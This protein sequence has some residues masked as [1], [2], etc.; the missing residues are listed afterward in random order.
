MALS[1]PNSKHMSCIKFTNEW[2]QTT[3]LWYQ[4]RP[5]CQLSHNNCPNCYGGY[6]ITLFREC[7]RRVWRK[8]T[9]VKLKSGQWLWLSWQR[10]YFQHQMSIVRIQAWEFL[11]TYIYNICLLFVNCWKDENEEKEAKW[12]THLENI[13][14]VL[15]YSSRSSFFMFLSGSLS[16]SLL[17]PHHIFISTMK[18]TFKRK[19]SNW[20]EMKKSLFISFIL[21]PTLW[22]R[23]VQK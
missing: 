20:R 4:K 23:E 17:F 10:G 13:S 19:G 18:V 7:H 15:L 9:H 8:I 21:R 2:I 22:L 12:K 1:R 11:Y 6:Q 16:L 5:L 3:D 14:K